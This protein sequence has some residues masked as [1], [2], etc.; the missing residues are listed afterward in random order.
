M[1]RFPENIVQNFLDTGS[2][3]LCKRREMYSNE[4]FNAV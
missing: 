1:V 4:S 2:Y 3:K